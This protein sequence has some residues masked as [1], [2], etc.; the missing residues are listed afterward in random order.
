[1]AKGTC[2]FESCQ[3]PSRIWGYCPGHAAQIKRG[4]TLAPLG[5]YSDTT[6]RD[7]EGRKRCPTCD[8]WKKTDEF[9]PSSRNRDGFA[10]Q[11]RRCDRALTVKNR[12]GITIEQH[13]KLLADQ[14]GV[15]AICGGGPGR[16]P[17]FSVDHD[18]TCCPGVKSCGACVRGLLCDTCNRVLGLF[19]D[20][21]ER[22]E[23]ASSYLRSR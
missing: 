15:C 6:V 22:F 20:E 11:C 19:D 4:K 2:G 3:K 13:D 21:P 1:M 17:S 10:S 18:H 12:Y 9:Y 14:G 23:K 8:T 5:A 7:A 16:H